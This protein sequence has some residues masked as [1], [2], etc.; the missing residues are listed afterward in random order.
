MDAGRG[1]A[2]VFGKEQNFRL[3]VAISFL[4][5]IVMFFLPLRI[6][7]T[8]VLILLIM[9]VLTMEILNTAFEN[10]SDLF[11]PRIHPYVRVV[12]DLMAG[13]V[14]ITAI[15]SLIIGLIILLPFFIGLVKLCIINKRARQ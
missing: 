6:W 8:V 5:L 11:K 1:I 7:E 12:K 14:L 10:F 4:I 3:Q 2:H 15:G 9:M 13:A